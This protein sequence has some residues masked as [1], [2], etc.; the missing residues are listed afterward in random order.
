M[1]S[2]GVAMTRLEMERTFP[3]FQRV[4]LTEEGIGALGCLWRTG[5]VAGHSPPDSVVGDVVI[6]R[7][8]GHLTSGH[9]KPEYWKPISK[10]TQRKID[11]TV[12]GEP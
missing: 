5:T 12:R 4:E 1:D 9:F 10:A 6:V 7:V 2:D 8:D 11:R 3:R